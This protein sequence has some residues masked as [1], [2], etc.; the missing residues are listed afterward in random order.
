VEHRRCCATT[1]ETRSYAHRPFGAGRQS[2][3]EHIRSLVGLLRNAFIRAILPGLE[4]LGEVNVELGRSS[5][6][7]RTSPARA[8]RATRT[9]AERAS[10]RA[11]R[12]WRHWWDQG[13][14]RQENTRVIE[15]LG[16][17]GAQGDRGCPGDSRL[18]DHD[19]AA[20]TLMQTRTMRVESF[21]QKTHDLRRLCLRRRPRGSGGGARGSGP[22]RS[23]RAPARRASRRCGSPSIST[24][25]SRA[26][27]SGGARRAEI[28]T[29]GYAIVARANV[30]EPFGGSVD[31]GVPAHSTTSGL[32][33]DSSVSLVATNEDGT[34]ARG[35]T[36]LLPSATAGR[37]SMLDRRS[38]SVHC[39]D[40]CSCPGR[41]PAELDDALPASMPTPFPSP[42]LH[43]AATAP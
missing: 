20:G 22:L 12:S 19:G 41:E 30:R 14:V 16:P 35:A 34:E 39:A 29:Q 27:G 18:P 25:S 23:R 42:I 17:E 11:P 40:R 24:T 28:E 10:A 8:G 1:P 9:S 7:R 33:C 43:P 26:D 2:Q 15:V 6:G 3:G 36:T 38:A 32:P 37:G 13:A 5:R 21:V 31:S 4:S